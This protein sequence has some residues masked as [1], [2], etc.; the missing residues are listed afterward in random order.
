MAGTGDIT[1]A[2]ATLGAAGWTCTSPSAYTGGPL[3]S[4][5][6]IGATVPASGAFTTIS[7]TGLISPTSTV[8][9]KGTITN[10]SVQA[11]SI[12]EFVTATVPV[13]SAVALT[14]AVAANVTS[15]SLTAGDWDVSSV[16][17]F[18]LAGATPTVLQSGPSLS[19]GVLPTQPGGAGLGTDGLTSMLSTVVAGTGV[20]VLGGNLVRLSI[21][22]TTT[23]FLVAS[24]TFSVGTIGAYGT[25]RARRKR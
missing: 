7:A 10:D 6:P 9:I 20:I 12:S 14:T 5:G 17:D 19:T 21:A 16:V 13:G 11:G 1:A 23:V 4:P 2:L 15:I 18:N 24:A 25:I 3:A 22:S 8:G